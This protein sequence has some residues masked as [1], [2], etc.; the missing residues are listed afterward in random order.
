M[1]RIT[2]KFSIFVMAIFLLFATKIYSQE[3][4]NLGFDT[5]NNKIEHLQSEFNLF[6]NLKISGYIQA[7]YQ[8][9]DSAGI[10]TYAGKD[11]P[12][13]VDKRF[14]LRRGRI[15][16]AYSTEL[17]QYV[18]QFD[19]TENQFATKDA[20]VRFTEPW[21][22]TISLQAGIFD[23]PF[24]YEIDYSSSLRESPERSRFTQTLFPGERDCGA[25]LVFQLP[26]T[27]PLNFI[28]IQGG[29][30]NGIGPSAPDFDKYK[31]FIGQI[32]LTKSFFNEKLKVGLGASYYN[33]GFA[34]ATKYVYKDIVTTAN[35]AKAYKVDSTTYAKGNEVK[36]EYMGIDCQITYD[37]PIGITTLR[38]EC[39]QGKQPG[40]NA[41]SASP[42]SALSG[43]VYI[44]NFNG[45][46]V[47][48]V[49]N[50]AKTKHQLVLKY[51]M[52]DPDKDVTGS[53]IGI[54]S[55]EKNKNKIVTNAGDVKFSTLGFGWIYHWDS[56][57]K[58]MAYYDMVKN[59]STKLAA[60]SKDLK[61]NVFT[62][63]VQYKF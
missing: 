18:L 36:R 54:L 60:Y 62:L 46:Y 55:T 41:S 1:N 26:K 34:T 10:K 44:R 11:F 53:E 38:G 12:A 51:D 50:I 35:G 57:V 15:K 7:Q 24:G 8:I 20:Y 21:A 37:S 16:F 30:F 4:Q 22:K 33:G 6:K 14:S 40:T 31:D 27:S 32:M 2:R 63:R 23:R 28:K 19:V 25:M 56:N 3:S 49:Q 48:F 29:M 39:I 13:G 45:Y 42:T 58:I 61:D 43:D 17:T 9:A 5:L 52:Y 59:E 47:Y